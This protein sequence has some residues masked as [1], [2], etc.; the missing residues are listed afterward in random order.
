MDKQFLLDNFYEKYINH[1]NITTS[2]IPKK[3]H[4]IWL[5]D[6]PSKVI[7][8]SDLIKLKHPNW[9]YKLWTYSDLNGFDILNKDLFYSLSNKGAQSDIFRYEILNKFGGIYLDTDFYMVKSFDHL[10]NLDFFSGNGADEPEVFNGLF[11]CTPNHPILI[12]I[13]EKLK[14]LRGNSVITINDVMSK[15]GPYLFADEVFNFLQNNK[16]SRCVVLPKEYFYSLPAVDRFSLRSQ[17]YNKNFILKN[18]TNN[19]IC[20]HLWE[21]SWQ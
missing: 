1:T 7:E 20:V 8:L 3:I 13:L 15:T 17:K 10:L 9:E 18:I 16:E 19:S 2:I 5:G 11:G 21:N 4:Q 14:D 12:N 6:I